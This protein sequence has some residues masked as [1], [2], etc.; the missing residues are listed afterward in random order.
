MRVER[1]VQVLLVASLM[2][3]CDH[4][5]PFTT[6]L[7]RPADGYE[8]G[9]PT[10]LTHSPIEIAGW[11]SD[12]RAFIVLGPREPAVRLPD[13]SFRPDGSEWCVGLI[14]ATGGSRFWEYCDDRL[15]QRDSLN[16]IVSASMATDGAL[17]LVEVT[18]PLA[19]S[20]Y[21]FPVGRNAEL[22]LSDTATPSQRRRLLQLYRDDIGRPVVSPGTINWLTR[23]AWAGS[24]RFVAK[25]GH[26]TPMPKAGVQ[27]QGLVVGE[28]SSDTTI[29][30]LV[31][32]LQGVESWSVTSSGDVLL[33]VG[34]QL[35]ML[36]MA[37]AAARELIADLPLMPGHHIATARCH[38]GECWAISKPNNDQIVDWQ[39][40][41]VSGG[42]VAEP[43]VVHQPS[44]PGMPRL[45]YRGR[46]LLVM[47]QRIG[48][49]LKALLPSD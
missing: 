36:S 6:T 7:D 31:D 45:S 3:G 10:R 22:W 41:R 44:P 1:C 11:T 40:W 28:I 39:L 4:T 20:G 16:H 27:W 21:K 23:L 12:D 43:I 13:G 42:V 34:S 37:A 18:G 30:R 15:S 29:L 26:L 33:V 25:A 8:A 38:A 49:L 17:L 46:D 5:A 9:P 14:P 24:N 32:D 2:S 35:W 19:T 47:H 48:Y